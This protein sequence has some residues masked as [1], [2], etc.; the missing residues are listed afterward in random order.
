MSKP[1]PGGR[2]TIMRTLSILVLAFAAAVLVG[3]QAVA[4]KPPNP[5]KAKGKVVASATGSGHLTQNAAFRTFA[6]TA[7]EHADGT[8]RGQAQLRERGTAP[9]RVHLRITCLNVV[10]DVAHMTGF[11]SRIRKE[12]APLLVKNSKVSF[13]VEDNGQTGDRVSPMTFHGDV[14]ALDCETTQ[15]APTLVVQRGQVKVRP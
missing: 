12:T 3:S 6:F 13:S 10:G 5:A 8:D 1:P 14:A 4:A 9:V 7:R 2:R 11:V 15:A